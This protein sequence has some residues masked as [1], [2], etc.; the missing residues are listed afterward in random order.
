M[1]YPD[2]TELVAEQERADEI[3]RMFNQSAPRAM[4]GETVESYKRRM[5]TKS[6]KT[7]LI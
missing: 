7:R 6:S 3:L 5:A 2:A 1:S 4:D